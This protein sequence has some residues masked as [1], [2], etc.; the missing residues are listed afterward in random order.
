VR[1]RV[2][3]WSASGVTLLLAAV[4]AETQ[5]D[6]LRTIEILAAGASAVH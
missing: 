4:Q 2:A 6:R 3:A 1:E 5:V